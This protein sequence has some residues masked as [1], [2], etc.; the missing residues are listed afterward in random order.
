MISITRAAEKGGGVE[1]SGLQNCKGLPE[2]TESLSDCCN[3]SQNFTQTWLRATFFICHGP[4]QKA[5]NRPANIR[6]VLARDK[7]EGATFN[8]RRKKGEKRNCQSFYRMWEKWPYFLREIGKITKWYD[9]SE[10]YT[11]VPPSCVNHTIHLAYHKTKRNQHGW[12]L[13]LAMEKCKQFNF[14]LLCKSSY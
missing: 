14:R 5:P 4:Q 6:V 7:G 12:L 8:K 2:A 11:T 9:E 10:N 1:C 13:H 3:N